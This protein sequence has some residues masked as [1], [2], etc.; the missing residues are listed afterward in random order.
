MSTSAR[1]AQLHTEIHR[2][3][4]HPDAHARI[5]SQHLLKGS[6]LFRDALV[7]LYAS[8][9]LFGLGS[10]LG[11]VVNLWRLKSLW[12]VGTA[13]MTGIGC[14]VYAALQLIREARIC[15]RVLND[16]AERL[17]SLGDGQET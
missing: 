14:L 13:T 7:S 12:I 17:E 9:G 1:F 2:L 5:L 11:G 6:G 8:V 16:H 4:D 15:L 10:L 3:M